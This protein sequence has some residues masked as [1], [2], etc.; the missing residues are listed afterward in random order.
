TS[1]G[2]GV[3]ELDGAVHRRDHGPQRGGE[4]A[5][6]HADTPTDRAVGALR[7]DERCGGGVAAPTDGVLG[8]VG[9]VEVGDVAEIVEVAAD[10]GDE[11][12]ER[13]V[14]LTHHR[15]GCAVDDELGGDRRD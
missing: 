10:A 6:V 14:A 11:G 12:G 5:V 1:S 8:V 9:D 3:V 4:D 2:G 7:L 13:S 15:A